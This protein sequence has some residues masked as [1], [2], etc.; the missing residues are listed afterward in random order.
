M[1]K[2]AMLSV[3]ILLLVGAVAPALSQGEELV[4]WSRYDLADTS[5]NNAVTLNARIEA[6]QEATGITVRYETVAWDQL[7]TKLAIAVQ[8][9]GDV[10]D[11]VEVGSQH[12]PS[13]LDAGALAPLDELLADEAFVTDLGDGDRL[14][15]V[16]EGVRYCVAHNV[17]GGMTYYRV[18]DFP[19]GYPQ[20]TEEWLAAAGTFTAADRFFSTQFAGRSYGAIEIAWWPMIYSNGGSIFDEEGKPAWATPEVAAVVEFAREIYASGALPEANITGDFADAEAPWMDGTAG[21]FRG[22]SWSAIFIPGL[23]DSVEAGEVG[24]TGGVA[25]GDGTP[26]V[27]M[28]SEGWAVPTGAA[29]PEGARAWLS[30]FMEPEFLATWAAAQ[31]GIPTTGAAYEASEFSGV[32]YQNVDTILGEQGLYMQQSPYYVESLDALA[33]AWQEMLL[34]PSIDALERLQQAA[35]EVL[36]RYW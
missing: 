19:D 1:K 18:A 3:L 33:I 30:G 12:V 7:S 25:F 17:R 35:D 29:N 23:Q 24:M 8:A 34:D 14:A 2:L 28:V 9:G 15:C 32:F 21:S 13:L 26:H 11:I 20:T 6:F 31:F 22:G 10:P 36:N 16:I 4:M 5:D 27:F